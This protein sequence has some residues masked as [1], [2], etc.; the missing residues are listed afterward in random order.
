MC[1][2]HFVYIT[3]SV[4][5]TLLPFKINNVTVVCLLF[6]ARATLFEKVCDSITSNPI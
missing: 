2:C 1:A 5:D 6:D 3:E 4:K